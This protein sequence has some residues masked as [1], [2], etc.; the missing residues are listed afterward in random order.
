MDEVEEAINAEVI[1]VFP[2]KVKVSVNDL[3]TFKIAE[4]SLRVGS[5]LKICD[6]ENVA[7]IC[8]IESFAIEMR[9]R[10]GDSQRTYMIEA[11][12]LGTLRDGIFK[13]GGDEL[14]IPP[15][16]VLPAT[17]AEIAAIYA[18]SCEMHERFCFASLTRQRGVKVPVHGDKFFNKHI[19]VVGATGSGKSSSVSTILQLATTAKS[20]EYSGL[21]NSHIVIFDIHSE[22]GTAFPKANVITVDDLILPYWMLND[23]EMEDMFLETGDANNYNQES[24]LRQIITLCKSLAHTEV[25]KVN[26]DSPLSYNIDHFTTC[27]SN[28]SR[29]MKDAD[30]SLNIAIK[31]GTYK[32]F[33]HD[34]ARLAHY[35][36]HKID[37]AE[38]AR[39][40]VNKGPY[41]DGSIDKFVRRIDAKITNPRLEFMFGPKAR[42]ATLEDVLRQILGYRKNGEANV[43]IID[44][45][46]VPFEFI[47]ITVSLITRLL[48][49]Y[50]YYARKKVGANRTPLLLVFEEAHKYAPKSSLA[51]YKASLSAIERVAKEGRKYGV[52]LLIA[53]Q[54]PSEIS[55]TI[56][57]QCSNFLAMR[58]TNPDDQSYVR[59]LLPDTLGNITTG[60]AALE[61][62]EALLIGDAVVMPC[63]VYVDLC[64]PEPSSNDIKYF[65]VWKDAWKDV[66][67]VASAADWRR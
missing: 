17:Q 26:F 4:E 14:A 58:L 64:N 6:N 38:A 32:K 63:V 51:R 16:Q 33:E 46:G 28:L 30:D 9:E 37:F 2:D 59:R 29:E 62:G 61:Q 67:F 36:L 54:R 50:C 15:K 19:A 20:G 5:F 34:K 57:S 8:I 27:L 56:F 22:Y 42:T 13:R 40:K 31:G 24:L 53:S 44:L 23:D 65:Q 25:A 10:D 21:N 1:S 18:N 47:S 11:Y 55:E 48:F 52:S 43:T 41:A 3:S 35:C 12:P 66:D 39:S 49:D 7:L 45:S 60:L